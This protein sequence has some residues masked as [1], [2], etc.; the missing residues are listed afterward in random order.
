MGAIIALVIFISVI[1]WIVSFCIRKIKDI[2]RQISEFE[3]YEFENRTPEGGV[4]FQNYEESRKHKS[5]KNRLIFRKVAVI[6]V[7]ILVFLTLMQSGGLLLLLFGGA[8]GS[9]L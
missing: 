6:V 8:I 9:F 3:K 2:N 1:I 4:Y 7:L 5:G